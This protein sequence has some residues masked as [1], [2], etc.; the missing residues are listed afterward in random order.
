MAIHASAAH[1]AL[2][3]EPVK[4][5]AFNIMAAVHAPTRISSVH[6]QRFAQPGAVEKVS[7]RLRCRISAG[8]QRF[9]QR[10]LQP[11]VDRLGIRLGLL[12]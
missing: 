8:I 11:F 4:L 10:L 6:V 5:K 1:S 3:L 9:I 7:Q 12:L 2:R